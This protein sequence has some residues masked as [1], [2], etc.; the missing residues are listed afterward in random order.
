MAAYSSYTRP[1][2]VAVIVIAYFAAPVIR[3]ADPFALYAAGGF[4]AAGFGLLTW[5]LLHGS[6]RGM[7][8]A[9]LIGIVTAGIG[10]VVLSLL[11]V[12]AQKVSEHL[13]RQCAVLE[14][15]MTRLRPA[16]SDSRELFVALG[17][18]GQG[19]STLKIPA[20]RGWIKRAE[21]LALIHP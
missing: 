1:F 2:V 10:A 21:S 3:F 9:S 19:I 16:R 12:P 11:A 13:D 14:L 5:A 6:G 15:D 4:L 20:G 18:H 17:C 8:A 7:R